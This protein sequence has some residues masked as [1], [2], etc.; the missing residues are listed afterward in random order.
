MKKI[1]ALLCVVLGLG[2]GAMGVHSLAG[3]S[4]VAEALAPAAEGCGP[5]ECSQAGQRCEAGGCPPAPEPT[6]QPKTPC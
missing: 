6:A 3:A 5:G 1:A 4:V 2:A